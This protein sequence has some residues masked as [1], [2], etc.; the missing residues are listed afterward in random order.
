MAIDISIRI[1]GKAGQGIQSISSA[2]GKVFTRHGYY[3]FINPDVESRIRGGHNFD[4]VRIKTKP[5]YA[6]DNNIDVLV[7]L[8]DETIQQDLPFL[9][10]KGVLIFDGKSN[11]FKSDNPNHISVPLEKIAV[12]TGKNKIM[13]NNKHRRLYWGKMAFSTIFRLGNQVCRLVEHR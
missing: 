11:E 6:V 9:N 3:A 12:E 7:A 2:M 8:D 5:V 4:Q 10:D 13:A 1:C